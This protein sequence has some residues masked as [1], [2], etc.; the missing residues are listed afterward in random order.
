MRMLA[1][2]KLSLLLVLFSF[3]IYGQQPGDYTPLRSSGQLPDRFTGL[4]RDR[5]EKDINTLKEESRSSRRYKKKYM[6]EANYVIDELI[7]SG[8]VL[9]N[10]P[11]GTYVNKVADELLKKTPELRKSISIYVVK[12]PVVNA[13]TFDN[14][15]IFINAGLLAQLENEA[16]LAFILSHEIIHFTK[17][18]A[19]NAYVEYE[20][21]D[22]SSYRRQ[23]FED[24]VTAK[25]TYS[26]ELETEADIEG[27]TLYLNSGYSLKSISGAFDVLQYSYLPFEEIEFEKSFLETKHLVLPDDYFLEQTSPIKGEEDYDDSKS[28][29]P[30]IEKRRSSI[31]ARL[32]DEPEGD[33]KKYLVS[34]QE[35]RQVRELARFELCRLYLIHRNYPDALYSAYILLKKYPGNAYLQEIVAK[36]LYAV[37]SYRNKPG[38]SYSTQPLLNS[39]GQEF[40]F[41][42][43]A[44][45]SRF[46][47]A[48][49]EDIEGASQ[50]V[51]HLLHKLEKDEMTAVALS[52][53]W[54]VAQRD[55]SDK[56][57]QAI[58]DSLF[59]QMVFSNKLSPRSFSRKPRAE[60]VPDTAAADQQA[61]PEEESKYSKIKA[62]QAKTQDTLKTDFVRYAF[63]DVPDSARFWSR[64]G[65]YSEK[66]LKSQTHSARMNEMSSNE[67][68]ALSRQQNKARKRLEKNGHALGI[69]K[70][71]IVDPYYNKIDRRKES[72]VRH[73]AAE[74]SQQQF[75]Q[76]LSDNARKVGLQY[77]L[78]DPGSFTPADVEKFNDY[79]VINDWVIE[80]FNHEDRSKMMVVNTDEA[81]KLVEKYGTKYFMWTGVMNVREKKENAALALI[82]SALLIY[83][84]PYGIYY[85]VTPDYETL[86]YTIMFDIETGDVKMFNVRSVDQKD[87]KDL[88]NSYIYDTFYQV[89]KSPAVKNEPAH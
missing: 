86:Y 72:S 50:Q 2:I 45:Q 9:V 37:A 54:N 33:R 60:A 31:N 80:R 59:A 29:H 87:T 30:N 38:I 19:I 62:K 78:I 16:Q 17:R 22:Q 14:G 82:V 53:A 67:L 58:T 26:K 12:S 11:L 25:S 1:P 65:M 43:Y 74:A 3:T 6:L 71:V 40:S 4:T 27:L 84:L 28:T 56:I 70:L 52:Y 18:H 49:Y 47:L 75:T 66:A 68:A 5:V 61:A 57:M 8:K 81:K 46:R 39:E 7:K 20:R 88:L 35:F 51:Y 13:F 36:S 77:E 79:S 44:D 42:D 32:G 63:V 83:P 64:F 41:D 15:M 34:E 69:E 85:A 73:I 21:I 48:K 76:M 55:T 89:R 24:R 23:S 10:D